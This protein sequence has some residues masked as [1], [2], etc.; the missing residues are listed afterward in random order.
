MS[1]GFREFALALGILESVMKPVLFNEVWHTSLGKLCPSRDSI[2]N[3]LLLRDIVF[4]V[5]VVD[6]VIATERRRNC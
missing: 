6:V 2:D 5:F 1:N 4:I 3:F